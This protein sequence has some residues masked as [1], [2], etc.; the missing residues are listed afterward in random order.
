MAVST[1]HPLY[2]EFLPD[3]RQLRDTKEGERKIKQKGIEYLPATA[4]MYAAGFGTADVNSKGSRAYGAYRT[5]AVF[6][7]LVKEALEAVLGVMHL[8][9]PT[10]ELPAAL[11]P[12]RARAT[13]RNESLEMLLHRINERQVLMGRMGL[14]LDVASGPGEKVPYVVVYEAEQVGNWDDG[15]RAADS[16]RRSLNLVVLDE[17][18]NVRTDAFEWEHLEKYRVA[19][20]GDVESNEQPEAGAKFRVAVVEQ[21]NGAGDIPAQEQF[22]EPSIA[23][24]TLEFIPFVFVNATDIVAEPERS[25]SM[26]LSNLA[27]TI[28]RGEADYRQSLFQQGQ[29]TLV[30]I[31][32]NKD[33]PEYMTGAHGVIPLPMNGDAKY[34]G[35]SSKGLPEQRAA[36]EN[37]YKRAAVMA[38][39]MLDTS[40]REKESGDALRVRVGAATA[41]LRR[42]ALTGAF[43]LQEILRM[44]ATWVGANPEEVIVTP[45][46]DFADDELASKTVLELMQAIA[47]GAPLARQS[48]HELL[49]KRGLT[50]R[51]WDEEL[52]A[53]EEESNLE[54]FQVSDTADPEQDERT[55]KPG[56]APAE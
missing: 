48:V 1:K 27:L 16:A 43:A 4:G 26:P 53:I 7:E 29:D 36:L 41:T 56:D 3:W 11:E 49:Q 5:R 31:G 15:G 12:M 46:L 8:K 21:R 17:S 2:T 40:S 23:G 45:N 54:V 32:D 13:L 14:L 28:Y 47:I 42:I 50:K 18:E 24:R 30:T 51:S 6:P 34:I 10:I 19:V 52:E 20:L 22:I 44:A 9:P 25:P 38:G 33:N 39:Q 37:D 35:V 55:G